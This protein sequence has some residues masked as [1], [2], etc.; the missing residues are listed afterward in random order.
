MITRLRNVWRA[1]TGW[2]WRWAAVL[3]AILLGCT[4]AEIIERATPEPR[5][6]SFVLIDDKATC[7]QAERMERLVESKLRAGEGDESTRIVLADIRRGLARA[8]C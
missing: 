3:G 8:G 1:W 7:S 2:R 5:N 6:V 4:V